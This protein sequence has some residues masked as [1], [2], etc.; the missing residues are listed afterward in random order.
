MA[1]YYLYEIRETK[2][3]NAVWWPT[4]FPTESQSRRAV[5]ESLAIY[6]DFT[7]EDTNNKNIKLYFNTQEDFLGFSTAMNN[8]ASTPGRNDYNNQNGIVATVLYNDYIEA[9]LPI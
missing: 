7:S 9:V 8:L 6:I 4:A 1:T 2:P 5:I 3:T